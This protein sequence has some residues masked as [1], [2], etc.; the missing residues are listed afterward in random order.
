M[1]FLLAD[2]EKANQAFADG[3]MFF[4]YEARWFAQMALLL[5]ASG[6]VLRL[7]DSNVAFNDSAGGGAAESFTSN[8]FV[9]NGAG[10][11]LTPIG[12]PASPTGQ[13]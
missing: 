3:R 9:A 4:A 5:I 10:S 2:W 12:Q 13:Q 8:R 11:P 7:S 1:D 6:A